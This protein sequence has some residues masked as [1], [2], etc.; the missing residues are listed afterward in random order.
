[1]YFLPVQFGAKQ[2]HKQQSQPLMQ[3]NLSGIR[4]VHQ[5]SSV[6][7]DNGK[8]I[9]PL[10]VW[11]AN[12]LK[13]KLLRLLRTVLSTGS[14]TTKTKYWAD[15]SEFIRSSTSRLGDSDIFEV[16][17]TPLTH[18]QWIDQFMVDQRRGRLIDLEHQLLIVGH[19]GNVY[20]LNQQAGQPELLFHPSP[21]VPLN[22]PSDNKR[23][24]LAQTIETASPTSPLADEH[25]FQALKEAKEKLEA[26]VLS[27]Q[28]DGSRAAAQKEIEIKTLNREVELLKRQLSGN[29][30]GQVQM[31]L[32]VEQM[33]QLVQEK[34]EWVATI[35]KNVHKIASDMF[36]AMMGG[37]NPDEV[38]R[39]MQEEG[40]QS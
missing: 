29:Q 32:E 30:T 7:Y 21:V 16:I 5:L 19:S 18:G 26:Q 9:E 1:M 36:L 6:S 4:V 25:V 8:L 31:Q 15:Q 38:F 10:L 40:K 37:E 34:E 22:T 14:T 3:N 2:T 33:R 24:E 39:K 11:D 13:F 28:A 12:T 27:L 17:E 23:A 35:E 20:R